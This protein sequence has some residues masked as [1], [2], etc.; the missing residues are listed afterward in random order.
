MESGIGWQGEN[1][2]GTRCSKLSLC[3]VE[4]FI[5]LWSSKNR[6]YLPLIFIPNAEEVFFGGRRL[7]FFF[8]LRGLYEIT[9]IIFDTLMDL[10]TRSNYL[11]WL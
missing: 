5:G 7:I 8:K 6:F 9:F 3:V 10:H 4:C 1:R 11:V 2:L